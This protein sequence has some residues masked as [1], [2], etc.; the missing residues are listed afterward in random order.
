MS[1][2]PLCVALTGA[3]GFVGRHVL[4]ALQAQG[5]AVRALLRDPRRLKRAGD[6]VT[7]VAGDLFDA[8]ALASLCRDADAVVHLVGIIDE[9]PAR[10]Q[11]FDRVHHQATVNLLAAA[12]AAGVKRWVHMSALGTR[13]PSHTPSEPMSDYHRTKWLAEEAVRAAGVDWT[14]FRPSIIHGPDGE[15]MQLVKGFWCNLFPPFVPY[16]GNRRTAGQLQPVWIED[17]AHCFAAA[18]ESRRAIGE[19][20]PLG[21]P[22]RYT[23]PDLYLAVKKHL[24]GARDKKIVGIPVWYA[25]MIAGLP[26]VPFNKGQVIMSQEDSICEIGKAQHDFEFAFAAF[27]EKLGEYGPRIG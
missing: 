8:A 15:F 1:K 10:G 16:F 12:K 25:R 24:P 27:E 9:K 18:V 20:Y 6:R 14:I 17:V 5:C 26:G 22:D 7:A 11:T 2:K 19:I 4:T 13:A 3:T 21:G 23:W